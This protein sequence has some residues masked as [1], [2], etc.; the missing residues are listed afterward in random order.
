MKFNCKFIFGLFLVLTIVICSNGIAYGNDLSK[1]TFEEVKGLAELGNA[2]AQYSLGNMYMDGKS[3][4]QD[5]NKA[6]EWYQKAAEQ[7]DLGAQFT[8]GSMYR[9]GKGVEADRVKSFAWFQKAAKQSEAKDPKTL[10]STESDTKADDVCKI[11]DFQKFIDAYS[12]LDLKQQL[13][14]V[15]IPFIVEVNNVD[16]DTELGLNNF[17]DLKITMNSLT[18]LR[19]CLKDRKKIIHSASDEKVIQQE[20][21][22][23]KLVYAKPF[24]NFWNAYDASYTESN[25]CWGYDINKENDNSYDVIMKSG[26]TFVLDMVKFAKV[27]DYWMA[28]AIVDDIHP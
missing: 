13:T 20:D 26:G 18:D 8:L 25:E 14:C 11:Q 4:Q 16:S 23:G 19:K 2:E 21:K 12:N 1:L 7:G 22:D 6:V 28:T 24:K 17:E 5:N 3:V 10:G 27:G 15:K 9:Y